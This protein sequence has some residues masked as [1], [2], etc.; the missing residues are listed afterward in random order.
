MNCL[1][2]RRMSLTDPG[3]QDAGYQRHRH[4]CVACRDY[5]V[6]SMDFEAGLREAMNIEVPEDLAARVLLAQA[7]AVE[8]APRRRWFGGWSIPG[9]VPGLAPG[10][11]MAAS[12]LLLVVVG[13][14]GMGDFSAPPLSLSAEVVAHIEAERDYLTQPGEVGEARLAALLEGVGARI[15]HSP[16][17]VSYAG[18]CE[19]RNKKGVHLVLQGERGPVP[20]LYV[21]GEKPGPTQRFEQ[22]GF[23]GELLAVGDGSLAVVGE[24]GEA[25]EPIIANLEQAIAWGP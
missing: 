8:Q 11:A 4:E 9:L 3:I 1:E 6:G 10:L 24:G 21:P 15:R 19:I 7:I 2:F 12:L 25:L 23:T 20:V 5:A 14:L 16:G 17:R 18:A 13:W 22:D